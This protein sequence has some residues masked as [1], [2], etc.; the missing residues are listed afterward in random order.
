MLQWLREWKQLKILKWVVSID[1]TFLLFVASLL[2]TREGERR[3]EE[4]E[5]EGEREE[6]QG[7]GVREKRG[8]EG[9]RGK[10]RIFCHLTHFDTYTYGS[11]KQEA[12]H[13]STNRHLS[14]SRIRAFKDLLLTT[15]MLLSA[16]AS[17]PGHTAIDSSLHLFQ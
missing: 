1:K 17:N 2:N 12:N 13:L 11:A 15:F 7:G 16:L 8:R 6:T 9:E 4:I 10:E 3:K 5:G 14:S